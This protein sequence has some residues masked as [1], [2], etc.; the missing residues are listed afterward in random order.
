[1][2]D[3]P[4]TLV[5]YAQWEPIKYFVHFDGNLAGGPAMQSLEIAYEQAFSLPPC[6]FVFENEGLVNSKFLGW[7]TARDG[8]GEGFADEASVINLCNEAGDSITLYAQWEDPEPAPTPDPGPGPDPG[9]DPEPSPEPGPDPGPAPSGGTD[10]SGST[11]GGDLADGSGAGA[12][13]VPAT[14]DIAGKGAAV[15][16]G[17]MLLALISAAAYRVR[18]AR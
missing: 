14:G 9:P 15:A 1:M 4:G 16:M 10:A 3:A 5:L 2:L 17:M 11:S 18:N 7:N 8:S 13:S 6:Q 12:G